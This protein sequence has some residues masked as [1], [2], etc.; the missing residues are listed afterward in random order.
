MQR[1]S[2]LD[3][4]FLHVETP[5][6]HMHVMAVVVLDPSTAPA[7]FDAE[8]LKARIAERL[9]GMPALRRRLLRVPFDLHHPLWVEDHGLDLDVHVRRAALPAP[10]GTR[11]LAELTGHLAGIQLDRSRPL[12]ELW[13]VEGLEQGLVAIV[14]KLHH[15]AIDGL[16]G[17]DLMAN[18][19]DLEPVPVEAGREAPPTPRAGPVPHPGPARLLLDASTALARQPARV[20]GALRSAAGSALRLGRQLRRE[21][22][23]TGI[24]LRAPRTSLNGSLTPRRSVAY[25]TVPLADVKQVRHAFGATVNDVVLAVCTGAL[26]R[27]LSSGEGLPERPLVAAVPTALPAEGPRSVGNR[28]SAMFA[29]LPTHLGDALERLRAVQETM[30]GAKLVHREVGGDVLAQLT[31]IPAPALFS[32]GVRLYERLGLADRHPPIV[33]LIVSNL[34]GPNVAVYCAGARMVNLFP[35][36]PLLAGAGLNVTVVSYLD[37]VHVGLMACTDLVPDVPRLAGAVPEALE[38]LV[39]AAAER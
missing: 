9:P 16:L 4:A 8:T 3:A 29:A 34:P 25:A 24:P 1:L 30:A 10:G 15:A 12:W 13:V 14:A 7:G 5:A 31:D 28:V 2:G 37:S 39:K 36:G 26:R 17:L 27:Y 38:E 11:E 22:V 20:V 19:F 18:L 32:G 6:H 23:T 35:M 21:P 33:N